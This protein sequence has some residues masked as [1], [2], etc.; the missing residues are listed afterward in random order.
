[1]QQHETTDWRRGLACWL[2]IAASACTGTISDEPAPYGSFPGENP[3]AENPATGPRGTS[4]SGS[5]PTNKP[6]GQA[7]QGGAA[8]QSSDVGRVDLHRLNNT[9]YDN[10]VR[11]LLG[12]TS[13]PARSFIADEKALGFDSIAAALGMT[14]AQY[15]QYFSAA[16]EL[17]ERTFA[18]AALRKRI[19]TCTPAVNADP[20]VC[21]RQIVTSFGLRAWRRPLETA[22]VDALLSVAQAA[23][24]LGESFDASIA[25]VVKG[26]LSAP[27][28]LYRVELDADPNSKTAHPLNGYELASR[29][30]Y[31]VWSTLP[32]QR[33]FDLAKDNK[34][35]DDATLDKELDRMLA[36]ARAE[37]F[38]SSFAGQ[39]LGLRDL[40]S[41]QVEP[42]VFPQWNE[43]LRSAMIRE[44]QLYFDEFLHGGRSFDEF[45]SAPVNF[46]DP[47]L[48]K[49]YGIATPSGSG[50]AQR[51]TQATKERQGFLGLA[52]FLTMTSFSYRTAPTLRGKW[53]LEN[54]LC[55]SIAPP[56]ADVPKLDEAASGG[57]LSQLNVRERLAEHRKNPTCAACHTLLDPIGLGLENFDA[58]GQHRS[59]YSPGD[60]VDASGMLPNGSSFNGLT[61][62]AD[63][64]ARDTRLQDCASQKLLTYALSREL[65][66]SDKGYLDDLRAAWP[67]TDKTLQSLLRL[68][69]HSDP[70]QQR[71]GEAVP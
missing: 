35:Q 41:H 46:V 6:S 49:L 65:V 54:L 52:S 19:V 64:L 51:V 71:R 61:E 15:E 25:Q 20:K 5:S 8:A 48:A 53:V 50:L 62:L 45:F 12:V 43:G 47:G 40:K 34:L 44:G 21:T 24:D 17:V 59:E 69:V 26:M 58:I 22:E 56:P 37:N 18:D 9:E 30:S 7:G 32:D 14:D 16:D 11:D 27:A 10:T 55:Q 23:R 3:D 28:F 1:M 39:W 38:S 66:M 70:F 68:I 63:I 13:T 29:L 36:D 33:L 67:Q 42:T 57:D 4:G 60:A 2:V 31:L